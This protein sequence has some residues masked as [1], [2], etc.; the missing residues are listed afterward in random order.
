[1]SNPVDDQ[2]FIQCTKLTSLKIYTYILFFYAL[3]ALPIYLGVLSGPVFIVISL[4][5]SVALL[6]M[7][8]R[9]RNEKFFRIYVGFVFTSWLVVSLFRRVNDLSTGW[10]DLNV[11]SLAPIVSCLCSI[12]FL[13]SDIRKFKK[14]IL[15]LSVIVTLQV[16]ALII[17]ILESVFF[18]ALYSFLTWVTPVLFMLY[19]VGNSKWVDVIMEDLYFIILWSTLLLSLYG[20][21]QYFFLPQWDLIWILNVPMTS[22]GIPAP[23]QFR[24]FSTLNSPMVFAPILSMFVLFIL[25][26]LTFFSIFILALAIL[27]LGLTYVRSSWLGL[28]AGLFLYILWLSKVDSKSA[29]RYLFLLLIAFLS[30][31]VVLEGTDAGLS[32]KERLDSMFNL[33]DDTSYNERLEFYSD[34]LLHSLGNFF[35]DGMGSIGRAQTLTHGQNVDTVFDSGFLQIL[36]TFGLLGG[37]LYFLSIGFVLTRVF[38]VYL[39]SKDSREIMA[40][41]IVITLFVQLIFSNR[42]IGPIGFFVF[43]FS[44]IAMSSY[45]RFKGMI[46]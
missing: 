2:A 42:L 28:A 30:L 4:V 21:V 18:A 44:G 43:L 38:F 31:I 35:G 16:I 10:H 39:N 20:L 37:A 33:T 41:I 8:G 6:V 1:M 36:F 22:V 17:G 26:R 14:L 11:Y 46:K 25:S 32:I 3:I 27:T 19:L 12:F 13:N 9:G 23:T 29:V 24:V 7:E 40:A 34:M 5:V 15:S 45:Y